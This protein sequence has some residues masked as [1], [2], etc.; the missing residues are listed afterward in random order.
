MDC[1]GYAGANSETT[2]VAG[3]TRARYSPSADSL[4]FV[5]RRLATFVLFLPE[6]KTMRYPLGY[7]VTSGKCHLVRLPWSSVRNHPFKPALDEPELT[8]SIQSG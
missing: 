1:F 2:L 6:A 4:K 7:N 3:E 5:W 8:I